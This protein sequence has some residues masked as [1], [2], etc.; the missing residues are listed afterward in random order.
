ME[1]R[2]T[3][4]ASAGLAIRRM[5]GLNRRAIATLE[6]LAVRYEGEG[7]IPDLNEVEPALWRA[8][9]L[10]DR[11]LAGSDREKGAWSSSD[12]EGWTSDNL[13]WSFPC[14]E[15]VGLIRRMVDWPCGRVVDIG[16]GCGLWTRVLRRELGVDR[17]LGLDPVPK[18]GSV[19]AATFEE[20]C[21]ATG[22]P[23]ETDVLLVS[24]LPCGG[25]PGDDLGLR[26][27]AT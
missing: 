24:R 1:V 11:R 22:G 13:G 6:R 18:D 25:Q 4:E 20:W 2:P 8:G 10:A 21:E 17:V 5:E 12:I 23:R 16:A 26:V 9:R 3:R 7:G 14:A 19:I 15:A 27:L